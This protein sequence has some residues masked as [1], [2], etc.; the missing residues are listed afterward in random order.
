MGQ[1][2]GDAEMNRIKLQRN[3]YHVEMFQHIDKVHRIMT[4]NAAT[5]VQVSGLEMC[6][7]PLNV[8]R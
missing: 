3:F 4:L 6:A 2:D 7:A 8:I 1:K 5:N